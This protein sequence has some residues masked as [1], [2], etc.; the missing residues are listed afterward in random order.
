MFT[1]GT[2]PPPGVK[3][4]WAEITAPVE[5]AVV[6]AAY[7]PGRRGAETDLLAF[8]VRRGRIDPWVA[9]ELEAGGHE[10]RAGPEEEHRGEDRPPLALVAD[11]PAERVGQREQD[12]QDREQLHEVREPRRVLE[13]VR[14]VRVDDPAAVRP[15]LLDRLLARD[16][17]AVDLLRRPPRRSWRW[18]FREVSGRR[19]GWQ[20]AA[21]SRLR[22]GAGSWW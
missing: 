12:Q 15:E 7:S 13:R 10:D 14:R 22:G 5:V 2:A 6:V 20:A 11:Y 8:H 17:P 4:S 19:P 16:G 21:R 18:R 3:L 1:S 9:V